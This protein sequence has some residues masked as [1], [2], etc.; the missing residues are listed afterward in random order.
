MKSSTH[1]RLNDVFD[2]EPIED[3]VPINNN[4]LVTEYKEPIREEDTTEEAE[5][6]SFK[7][8]ISDDYDIARSNLKNLIEYGE[9][10]VELAIRSAQDTEDSRS[11]DSATKALNN[12][13]NLNERLLNLT[14]VKQDVYM[15][16]RQKP[17]QGNKFG[18]VGDSVDTPPVIQQV[19]NNNTLFVGTNA[20]LAKMI[21]QIKS[22]QLKDFTIDETP[23]TNWL[24]GTHIFDS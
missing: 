21:K 15:K 24:Y 19:T 6:D 23:V 8:D 18:M 12:L 4:A 2:L 1:Q 3:I 10:I 5:D 17:N 20:E 9:M 14:T 16:T 11:I 22:E 13:A 7:E